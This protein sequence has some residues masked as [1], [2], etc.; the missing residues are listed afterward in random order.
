ML[1]PWF[2]PPKS[3]S[4]LVMNCPGSSVVTCQNDF[5]NQLGRCNYRRHVVS[6]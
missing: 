5:Q 2:K 6:E 1:F 3:F 4:T